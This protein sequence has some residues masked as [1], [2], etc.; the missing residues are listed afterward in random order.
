MTTAAMG[1]RSSR[2]RG[3]TFLGLCTR[4]TVMSEA[5][6]KRGGLPPLPATR[7][8]S[9]NANV[10]AQPLTLAWGWLSQ[11]VSRTARP[12]TLDPGVKVRV[13]VPQLHYNVAA[14]GPI[15]N[16][17]SG[18]SS[19]HASA[20]RSPELIPLRQKASWATRISRTR[21]SCCGRATTPRTASTTYRVVPEG[22]LRTPDCRRVRG[23][24][25]RRGTRRRGP[26][27]FDPRLSAYKPPRVEHRARS[28]PRREEHSAHRVT[29]ESRVACLPRLHR[30]SSAEHLTRHA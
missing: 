24:A 12:R 27:R 22:R 7:A 11:S 14:T 23:C 4:T 29:R 10:K 1:R 6:R 20:W 30:D 26:W 18:A 19:T 28:S 3:S 13:L 21:A 5:S 16:S 2:R 9:R 17:R 15:L 8:T 25:G